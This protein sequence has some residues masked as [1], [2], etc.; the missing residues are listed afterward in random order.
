MHGMAAVGVWWSLQ[1]GEQAGT[2][3]PACHSLGAPASVVVES[4]IWTLACE[5]LGGF[6]VCW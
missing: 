5:I 1:Q 6:L 4:V 2:G 3:I